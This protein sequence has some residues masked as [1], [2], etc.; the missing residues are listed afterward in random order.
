MKKNILI[1]FLGI[2]LMMAS[3]AAFE[4]LVPAQNVKNIEIE[5]PRGATFRQAV[6]ILSRDN[7]IRDKK[8][9]LLAGRLS[10]ADRR[11]RAGYYSIW[12]NMSPLAILRLLRSGQI[13]EY[14]IKIVEGDSLG[15]IAE[16]F[17]S[18]GITTK[19]DFMKLSVDADF[20]ASYEIE[21]PSFEGYLFPDTYKIPKG[22]RLEDAV[23]MMIDKM[24]EKFSDELQAKA[25]QMGMSENEVLT[26]ASIV[27]KEAVE[28]S[29]RP[30]I[31]A[32]YHNRLIKGMLLQADPTSVY[33]IKSS[34]EKIT[35][36]D[37]T[38]KTAY[39]T[40]L[41]KGLPPGP[42]ACPGLKSIEAALSPARVPYL[43]FVSRDNRYHQFST[44][45]AEH[46][47]AVKLYRER[48]EGMKNGTPPQEAES[49]GTS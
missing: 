45:I 5:I 11:I 24:R 33:G 4:L 6:E 39:N 19:Q 1:I 14:E 28:D 30:L 37:L 49:H 31:S 20:L 29:E 2:S 26:L 41:V 9:F 21:A 43:Y 17:A 22:I 15:E 36:S 16:A 23:G 10:N 3:Y 27:E 47:D 42:I 25:D 32:V 8:I 13:I 46:M 44:T 35:R 40:Y 18:A 7:L 12:D 48:Q 38:R 34:R